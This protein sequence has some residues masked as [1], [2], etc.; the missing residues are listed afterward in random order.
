MGRVKGNGGGRK[1]MRG[2]KRWRWKREEG[3]GWRYQEEMGRGIIWE[4]NEVM[5]SKI[6]GVSV[7][8]CARR[9]GRLRAERWNIDFG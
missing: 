7:G 1:L 5:G 8:E 6:V 2:W 9:L 3:E 4:R